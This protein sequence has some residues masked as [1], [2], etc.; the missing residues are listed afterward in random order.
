[1]SVSLPMEVVNGDEPFVVFNDKGNRQHVG[2]AI[3]DDDDAE[4]V[5]NSEDPR[6]IADDFKQSM[7][8][9][10]MDEH[11]FLMFE[12]ADDNE[13]RIVGVIVST[14]REYA[15]GFAHGSGTNRVYDLY[16]GKVMKV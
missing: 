12:N 6:D 4:Y 9:K 1:M 13:F 3:V 15:V 10:Q 16:E 7:K 2:F 11:P 5:F 8:Y 14:S